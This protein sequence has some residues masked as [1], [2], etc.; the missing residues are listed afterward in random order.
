M[1]S[2]PL[3]LSGEFASYSDA[4][5]EACS[6][7]TATGSTVMNNVEA[8]SR[9]MLLWRS[10]MH[11]LGGMGFVVLS[12]AVLPLLNLGGMQLYKAELPSPSP[13]RLRLRIKDTVRFLWR[14]YLLLTL[15]AGLAFYMGGMSFFDALNHAMST[16]S[17]GGFSTRNA[18][19]GAYHSPLLEW[20][21]IVFMAA[22][23]VNFSL[24]FWLLRRRNIWNNG[25]LRCYLGLIACCS[26]SVFVFL[27][28][29]GGEQ[30]PEALRHSFFQVTSLVSTTGFSSADYG[31]WPA[32]G[33][34]FLIIAMLAGGCAGSTSGGPKIMRWLV[35]FKFVLNE[36][37][38]AVHP[39]SI[40]S[41][42]IS[43]QPVDRAVITAVSGFFGLYFSCLFLS[44]LGLCLMGLSLETAFSASLSSLGNIGP[45]LGELGPANTYAG[46]PAAGKWL[47]SL[48]MLLGRLEVF[49]LLVLF[50][51]SFWRT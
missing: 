32:G 22:A 49:P 14:I 51:P 45:G 18:S 21:C 28:L 6:G 33:Q 31:Q 50:M 35:W 20:I 38:Q 13:D 24:Y 10:L 12:L 9:G 40:N 34:W 4:L 39:R 44:A 47:L 17:S 15:L 36:L 25:E 5:F 19:L 41:V 16:L 43:G 37:K 27:L 23:G 30:W 8:A 26:L 11:W 7:M 29:R 3:H 1:C 46:L 48:A 2:L 42:K